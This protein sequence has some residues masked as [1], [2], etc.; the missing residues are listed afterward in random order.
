MG[1]A[2]R[3]IGGDD[4]GL[5][6]RHGDHLGSTSVL[7]DEDGLKVDDSEV[8]YAPFGEIREGNQ[9][10][11]T[12]FG[13]TGQR[14][15]SSTGGLMYYG[16]RYYL[17]ELR[18]FISADTIVPSVSNPQSLNRYSY[19]YNNPVRHTDP[20]GH[21][22]PGDDDCWAYEWHK[23]HKY[24][25]GS[26]AGNK[27]KSEMETA[28]SL[29]D[30]TSKSS[31][32]VYGS[33]NT[34]DKSFWLPRSQVGD[35]QLDGSWCRGWQCKNAYDAAEQ[36]F[37]D[38]LESPIEQGEKF[39]PNREELTDEFGTFR[40]GKGYHP[41]LDISEGG[42]GS[43]IF[44]A[45]GGEVVAIGNDDAGLGNYVVIEHT[46]EDFGGFTFYSVYAHM[47]D[48]SVVVGKGSVSAGQELGTMGWTGLA[49][50]DDTHLH[51]EVRR[52][53]NMN[54]GAKNPFSTHGTTSTYDYYG[55]NPLDVEQRWVNLNPL[56]RED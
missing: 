3:I 47:E 24:N 33:L 22:P 37:L 53:N 18:R 8:V 12:D 54:V 6:F 51:F 30:E 11:L 19:V 52:A 29:E 2:F 35:T 27:L 39:N 17:P 10:A 49:S 4:A 34:G 16:A 41:G 31:D 32:T 23:A 25:S 45:A 7:S 21:C 40:S 50:K 1:G 5:Y 14:L 48:D 56:I 38:S 26:G 20:S 28:T 42:E 44:A 36:K 15:D 55:K 46:V 9:S 13:Y 43:P